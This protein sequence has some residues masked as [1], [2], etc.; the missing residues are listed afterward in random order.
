MSHAR[1]NERRHAELSLDLVVLVGQGI[2]GNQVSS[3]P[4]QT[5]PSIVSGPRRHRGRCHPRGRSRGWRRPCWNSCSVDAP[6]VPLTPDP[7][8]EPPLPEISLRR[9]YPAISVSSSLAAITGPPPWH[10]GVD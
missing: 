6:A 3:G 9:A 8:L 5:L 7:C 10:S 2:D 1:A 4:G